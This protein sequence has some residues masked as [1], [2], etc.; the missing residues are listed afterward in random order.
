MKGWSD[1]DNAAKIFPCTSNEERRNLFGLYFYLTEPVDPALLAE[2]LENTIERFKVFKVRLRTGIFWYYLEENRRMPEVFPESPYLLSPI[3]PYANNGYLFRVS[4]FEN[5]IGLEVFHSLTDGYGAMQFLKALVYTYLRLCGHEIDP[6]GLIRGESES[7]FEEYQDSFQKL[8]DA[9]VKVDTSEKRACLISGTRYED[10]W[11][12]VICGS[13]PKDAFKK[14]ITEYDCSY[15][16]FLTA[17]LTWSAARVPHLFRKTKKYPFQVFIPVDIRKR[18]ETKT[19]RNFSMVV[20]TSILP[21]PKVSF[22]DCVKLVKE[23]I[24]E[25]SRDEAFLPR[26]YGNIRSEKIFLLRIVP[27]FLKNI[28]MR[29]VY[30]RLSERANSFCLSNLGDPGIPTGMQKYIDRVIFSN[31]ATHSA[32]INMGVT[33]YGGKVYMTMTSAIMERDLQKQFFRLLTGLGLPVTL[34]TNDLETE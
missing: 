4:Y 19:L 16:Q 31:G 1:L 22:A 32:P 34:E 26:V 18:F 17:A 25:A 5:K 14:V 3:E 6:E 24:T 30:N 2:A 28:V 21:D 29:A 8:Y 7:V 11:L 9:G 12:G 27:L 23:Q 13:V 10:G 15:T 20:R 33:Y